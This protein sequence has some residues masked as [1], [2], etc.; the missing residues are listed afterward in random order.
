MDKNDGLYKCKI[1]NKEY[2]SYKS[3]WNHNKI[4]HKILS[5]ISTKNHIFT[6]KN[7]ILPQFP[8]QN[9]C[10]RCDKT[11][12][13]LD[14]LK[15][16]QKTCK[17]DIIIELKE[18]INEL[19]IKIN[20]SNNKIINNNKNQIN[21]GTII[22]NN[23]KVSFGYENIDDLS[24]KDQLK[25]L[26]SGYMSLINLIDKLHLN[27]ELPQYNNILV[28]N[29]KDKYCK[30]YDDEINKYKTINKKEMIDNIIT[31]RT[32]NLKEIY[33]KY[34][35][36]N[37]KMH[38]FVLLLIEKLRSITPDDEELMKYYKD[39]YEEIILLIYNKTEIYEKNIII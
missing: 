23:I 26:N 32:N 25:I 35:N 27:P 16:H 7:H 6:T 30:I 18:E 17:I 19:K 2:K 8:I 5:Q 21:N 24:K 14:S 36:K 13:R 29:L 39:L 22:N 9:K 20:N 15:R 3:L 31:L 4:K 38:Q 33:N 37:N 12:S 1:C 10:I 34:N 28:T 11:F